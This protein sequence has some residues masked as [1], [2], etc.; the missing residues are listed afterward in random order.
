MKYVCSLV[1]CCFL[2]TGCVG[3]EIIDEVPI[4]FIVGY[5][6]GVDEKIKG[7]ISLQTFDPNQEVETR[8]FEAEAHTSKGLRNQLS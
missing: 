2:L 7:T 5:D 1:I 4:L 3:E 6:Q 8:A